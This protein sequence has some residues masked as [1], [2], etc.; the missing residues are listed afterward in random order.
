MP[1]NFLG[2]PD[3]E[4]SGANGEINLASIIHLVCFI[5]RQGL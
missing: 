4:K 1:K 5:W 3:R 2:G